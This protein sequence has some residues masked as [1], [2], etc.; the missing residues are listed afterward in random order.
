ME[1]DDIFTGF[2]RDE[3]FKKPHWKEKQDKWGKYWG[4]TVEEANELRG[5]QPVRDQIDTFRIRLERKR[6]YDEFR[7]RLFKT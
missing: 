1:N 2:A 7:R 3:R 6:M 4:L 5:L